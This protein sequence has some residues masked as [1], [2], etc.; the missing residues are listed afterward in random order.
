MQTVAI[1]CL[2]AKIPV[3]LHFLAFLVSLRWN[4]G[5]HFSSV[6]FPGRTGRCT[7]AMTEVESSVS[8]YVFFAAERR[9]ALNVSEKTVMNFVWRD[10]TPN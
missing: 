2:S 3:F 4:F 1:P 8:V 7:W 6:V 10:L 9:S 5:V